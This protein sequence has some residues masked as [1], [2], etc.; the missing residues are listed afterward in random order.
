MIVSFDSSIKSWLGS[1]ASVAVAHYA[2]KFHEDCYDLIP[3]TC[4]NKVSDGHRWYDQERKH[5]NCD[6]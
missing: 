1:T 2:V 4:M 5:S 3:G 6:H